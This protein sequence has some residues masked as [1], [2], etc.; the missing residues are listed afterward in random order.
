MSDGVGYS[1]SLSVYIH[2]RMALKVDDRLV[3]KGQGSFPLRPPSRLLFRINSTTRQVLVRLLQLRFSVST[4]STGLQ[5]FTHVVSQIA[6]IHV[7]LKID[8]L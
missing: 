2:R 7:F 4:C 3:R 5:Q 1:R 8:I 6:L